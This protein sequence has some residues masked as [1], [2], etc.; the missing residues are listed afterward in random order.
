MEFQIYT[1]KGNWLDT[2]DAPTAVAA[3]QCL[4]NENQVETTHGEFLMVVPN[5]AQ[6]RLARLIRVE[7]PARG[8]AVEVV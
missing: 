5:I 2:Q 4:I 1:T 3:A 6:G 8:L 7:K